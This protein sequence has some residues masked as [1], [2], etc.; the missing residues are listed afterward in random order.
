MD[1]SRSLNVNMVFSK[2]V[3]ETSG[4]FIFKS[5]FEESGAPVSDMVKSD[6]LKPFWVKP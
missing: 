4:I 2:L 3:Y 5:T 1:N 6:M